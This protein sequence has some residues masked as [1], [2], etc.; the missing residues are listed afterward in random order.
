MG[1]STLM[2]SLKSWVEDEEVVCDNKFGL[3]SRN[4]DHTKTL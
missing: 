3:C 2:V 4:A 1:R